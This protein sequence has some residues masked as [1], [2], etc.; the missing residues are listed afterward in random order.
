VEPVAAVS[1]DIVDGVPMLDLNYAED[2]SAQVDLNLVMTGKGEFIEV[3]GTG[4]KSTFTSDQL[5]QLLE[6]GKAGIQRLLRAQEDA[7]AGE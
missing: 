4:E 6:L 2:S 1:V 3:Q 5:N 7:L